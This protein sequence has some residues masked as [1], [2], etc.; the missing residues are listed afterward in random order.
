MGDYF[1]IFRYQ[2][3]QHETAYQTPR[4]AFD[5][6]FDSAVPDAGIYGF[7]SVSKKYDLEQRSARGRGRRSRAANGPEFRD[8]LNHVQPP[9]NLT[10]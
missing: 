1:R 3:T 6:E 10:G 2:G 7:G 8:R 4:Y 5:M 9:R